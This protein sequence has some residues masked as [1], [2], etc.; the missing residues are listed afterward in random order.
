MLYTQEFLVCASHS[1]CVLS[2]CGTAMA[3][4]N[5]CVI[6]EIETDKEE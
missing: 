6:R 3:G 4:E 1:G 2:G 5:K